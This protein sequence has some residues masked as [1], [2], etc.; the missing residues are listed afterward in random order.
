MKLDVDSPPGL[1]ALRI[2]V[3]DQPMGSMQPDVP[4]PF[5]DGVFP[6]DLLA[7]VQRTVADGSHPALMVIHDD[8]QDWLL[9]DGLH[10]PNI[11]GA[12]IVCHL[13][14][15]LNRDPSIAALASLPP[16]HIAERVSQDEPWSIRPWTYEDEPSS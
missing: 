1:C 2:D 15:V 5:V 4:W 3:H 12:S 6:Q 11:D 16:G 8:E 10:D 7:I 14:H 9:A 13:D